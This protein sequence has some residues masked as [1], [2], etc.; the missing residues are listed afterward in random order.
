M[1]LLPHQTDKTSAPTKETGFQKYLFRTDLNIGIYNI[2]SDPS[3]PGHYWIRFNA[4]APFYGINFYLYA[5]RTMQR[6]TK[7]CKFDTSV[8]QTL[9]GEP[10]ARE[11]LSFTRHSFASKVRANESGQYI[12]C[13]ELELNQDL[14]QQ[15]S[16]MLLLVQKRHQKD[17]LSMV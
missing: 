15:Y 8:D 6:V 7:R 13:V 4:A 1:H 11:D 16:T 2:V 5:S 10:V 12:F 3:K 9:A 14:T 17:L